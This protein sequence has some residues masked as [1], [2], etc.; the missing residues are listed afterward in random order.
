MSD[1]DEIPEVEGDLPDFSTL[2]KVG[3][4]SRGSRYEQEMRRL[5]N[6]RAAEKSRLFDP[7]SGKPR[8]PRT[9]GMTV[10][11]F[12][13]LVAERRDEVRES[14]LGLSLDD[15]LVEAYDQY[16]KH[17]W[18]YQRYEQRMAAQDRYE[19]ERGRPPQLNTMHLNS[20]REEEKWGTEVLLRVLF[21]I[22]QE[23][24]KQRALPAANGRSSSFL[25]EQL[26]G[27]PRP[28][29]ELPSG[30][31]DQ[32][33]ALLRAARGNTAFMEEEEAEIRWAAEQMPDRIPGV[34]R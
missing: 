17:K 3:K 29:P 9:S 16:Q 21:P 2:E 7:V 12:A 28:Q 23:R 24:E 10:G 8:P 32:D 27:N 15:L 1:V 5:K 11:E 4:R 34:P 20:M 19:T 13:A 6:E 31:D 33:D 30:L 26:A 22:I 14:V 18:R 25:E